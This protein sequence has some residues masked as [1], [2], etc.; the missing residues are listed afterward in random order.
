[1]TWIDHPWSFFFYKARLFNYFNIDMV[2]ILMYK[3][4]IYHRNVLSK[5]IP[6]SVQGCFVDG[7]LALAPTK[8]FLEGLIHWALTK[9]ARI[10]S[11]SALYSCSY[12]VPLRTL[13]KLKKTVPDLLWF[14]SIYQD[15]CSTC[16]LLLLER[17][18]GLC[19]SLFLFV[20]DV[21]ADVEDTNNGTWSIISTWEVFARC[22]ESCEIIH[23]I[24]IV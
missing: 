5:R 11:E 22:K 6:S 9:A 24:V 10:P 8:E 3:I 2:W 7:D 21:I 13:P 19:S 4:G 18:S 23:A 14:M 17:H 15:L 20:N 12:M 1:M 16:W